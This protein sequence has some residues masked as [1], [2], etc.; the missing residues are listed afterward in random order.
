[1]ASESS[2]DKKSLQAYKEQLPLFSVHGSS[3]PSNTLGSAP[4]ETDKRRKLATLLAS[5]LNF[6]GENGNY[7]SHHLHAFAARF[8]PQL[9]RAFIQGL[10]VPGDIVL[11][12]MMGSGTAVVEAWLEGRRGIGL[13]IDPL[14]LCLCQVKTRP[15]QLEHLQDTAQKVVAQAYTLTEGTTITRHLAQRFD[16]RTKAFVNYWFL[17]TTQRDLMALRVAIESV[18]EV[19]VRR[20]LELTFSSTIITKSG[21][22]TRARDLAHSRPHLDKEKVPKNA[23]EQFTLR[24]HKNLTS[25]A[26]LAV[27]GSVAVPLA[28]DARTMPFADGV[29]DLIVTS[30]PYANALDYMRAHKFSLVW[31]GKSVGDLSGLRA[32]YIGAERVKG[33]QFATLPERPARILGELAHVDKSKSAILAKYFTEM[34]AVL[35]EMH[36]VLRPDAAAVVVV[37]PSVMRGIDVQTHHGLA[38]IAAAVGF[39][40]VGVVQR[41]LDRNKRMMPARFRKTDSMI[42]QRMHEEYVIG[43]WKPPS[44]SAPTSG[45]AACTA[46]SFTPQGRAQFL[47]ASPHPSRTSAGTG[48]RQC[49]RGH[50]RPGGPAYGHGLRTAGP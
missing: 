38:D 2:A 1:M 4:Q 35:A 17:P 29:I 27:N 40:V 34:Q 47:P 9:P 8:P 28:G 30:P 7:A 41:M 3:D 15:L 45:Q 5:D 24:L 48:L 39:D 50:S 6:H 12:P 20:L 22:V 46:L 23:L 14:A 21:G 10:T 18:P 37:G 44:A 43:L 11:D 33:T 32:E 16:E 49:P 19:A 42:E 25:I 36:R 13:D 31:L 26:A